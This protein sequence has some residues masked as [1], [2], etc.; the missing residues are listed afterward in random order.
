MQPSPIS[1]H[2]PHTAEARLRLLVTD[3]RKDAAVALVRKYTSLGPEDAM[4]IVNTMLEEQHRSRRVSRAG[5]E[6]ETWRQAAQTADAGADPAASFALA[7]RQARRRAGD[8]TYDHL[9]AV[10]SYST[11]TISRAFAGRTLP[12]WPVVERVLTALGVPGE[13]IFREWRERWAQAQDQRRPITLQHPAGTAPAAAI[14]V[15]AAADNGT[16]LPDPGRL[17]PAGSG[18][19]QAAGR[20]CEDC[21]ALIANIVQHQAWH[22]RIEKQLRRSAIRAVDSTG[23]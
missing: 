4:N 3:G 9:A 5:P 2:L 22:W 21:G 16:D 20:E 1:G 23:Q 12:R 13:E 15:D 17:L 18:Q 10:T 14:P 8:M 19:P 6:G 11:Q 7:L